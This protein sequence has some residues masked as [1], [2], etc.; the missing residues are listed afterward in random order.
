[1]RTRRH[2]VAA[3]AA[4]ALA[5]ALTACAGSP[6]SDDAT[7]GSPSG[8]S[9]PPF[10]TTSPMAP[11]GTPTQVPETRWSAI[12]ADLASRAV[13]GTPELVSAEAVTFNDGSLGCAKPGQSYTQAIVDG[14]RVIV[15]VEDVRYDYRFGTGDSPK[16]CER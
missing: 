10:I 3:S 14:M 16:L 6:M 4:A 9:R 11:T 5:F 1:M 8:S 2:M 12:L 7:P 15:T 13:T